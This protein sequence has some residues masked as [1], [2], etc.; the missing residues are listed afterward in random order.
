MKKDAHPPQN[1]S[2]PEVDYT[3]ELHEALEVLDGMKR[4]AVS[5]GMAS[6]AVDVLID[7]VRQVDAEIVAA[8]HVRRNRE[9]SPYFP[10]SYQAEEDGLEDAEKLLRSP[11][12]QRR[13]DVE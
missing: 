13:E 1:V 4:Q 9:L 6:A 5:L 7:G 3:A 8:R 10:E 2:A 12:P 11:L